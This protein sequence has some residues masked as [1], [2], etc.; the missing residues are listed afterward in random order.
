VNVF[1]KATHDHVGDRSMNQMYLC[2]GTDI[3]RVGGGVEYYPLGAMGN[4]DL[5]LHAAYVYNFGDNTNPYGTAVNKGSFLTV[6]L[7][8]KI[9]VVEGIK[10]LANK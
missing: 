3:T 2:H 8:W 10:K 5:R 4:R 7:T 9:D 6:G 1:V